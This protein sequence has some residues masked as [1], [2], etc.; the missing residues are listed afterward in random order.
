MVN[1]QEGLLPENVAFRHTA[2]QS[3]LYGTW[4]SEYGVDGVRD[5]CTHTNTQTDPWW[6]VDL[7][8]VYRV[9][10]VA[11]TNR[12][13]YYYFRINGA[14]IR[15]GNSPN[16]YSNPICAVIPTI[17]SGATANFSCGAMEGRYVIIHIPG[18]GKILT[19]CEVEVYTYL[20]ERI[21]GVEIRIGNSLENNGN[22]NPICAVIPAIPAGESY[23]YSCGGMEGRYVNLIIPG[24]MKILTL[25]E[26]EVYGEGPVLKRSFVK[27]QFNSR[28]DLTDPSIGE[29]VL[30][31]MGSA[32]AD[33]GFTNV[34]LRWFKTPKREVMGKVGTAI[35]HCDKG[36]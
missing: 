6:R 11:I 33:G 2:T 16:V 20:G 28:A 24:D 8:K 9:N 36:K 1:G 26:V 32:L 27:M 29:N 23:S 5:S 17:P 19:L 35:S 7:M 10:R 13:N 30:K 21:D 12:L 22:N 34:T 14:V 18:D 4:Y 31:Q 15:V 3:S 25:C